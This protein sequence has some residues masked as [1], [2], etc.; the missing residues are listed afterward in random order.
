MFLQDS[1]L[2]SAQVGVVKINFMLRLSSF[3][4]V[5]VRFC[6]NINIFTS[7]TDRHAFAVFL[8]RRCACRDLTAVHIRTLQRRRGGDLR[9]G[10]KSS[11]RHGGTH[12]PAVASSHLLASRRSA[13]KTWWLMCSMGIR[14]SSVR[15]VGSIEANSTT[16]RTF[17]ST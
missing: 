13:E 3:S 11:E 10:T 7:F 6:A 2:Q 4:V 12:R 14:R 15:V 5:A 9:R 16:R 1:S 8:S 17:W